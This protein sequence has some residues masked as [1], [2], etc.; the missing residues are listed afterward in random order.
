MT[1][2]E[3]QSERVQLQKGNLLK[4]W[5]DLEPCN[6]LLS[7]MTPLPPKHKGKTFGLDGIRID[8]SKQFVLAVLSR[9]K[10]LIDGENQVTRLQLAMQNCDN[11]EGD[12][13]KGNG[14]YVCYVRLHC[15]TAQGAATSAFFDK[16]LRKATENFA[17]AIGA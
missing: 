8:G 3:R 1:E 9:V 5:K 15:R 7:K 13:N 12:F 11:A 2:M 4:T 17:E 6:N 10:D 16:D 14:G